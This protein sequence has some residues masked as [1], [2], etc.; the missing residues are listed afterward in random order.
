MKKRYKD[1]L[2][3]PLFCYSCNNLTI[4]E[5]FSPDDW[6]DEYKAFREKYHDNPIEVGSKYPNREN[7]H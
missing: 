7:K 3:D 5:N 6:C 4:D 1:P 2:K